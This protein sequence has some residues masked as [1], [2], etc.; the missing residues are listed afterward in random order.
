MWNEVFYKIK[1]MNKLKFCYLPVLYLGDVF[2][3]AGGPATCT[4]ANTQDSVYTEIQTST[5]LGEANFIRSGQVTVIPQSPNHKTI[6]ALAPYTIT[7]E[8]G[9]IIYVSTQ[10]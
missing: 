10:F 3:Y 2:V 1:K 7:F 9:N 8:T 4:F 5:G 6:C